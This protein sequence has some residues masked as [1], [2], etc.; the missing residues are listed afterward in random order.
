MVFQ[1]VPIMQLNTGLPLED[2]WAIASASVFPVQS[3][4]VQCTSLE[5]IRS[6]HI[7]AC[8]PLCVH[9][10][11]RELFELSWFHMYCNPKCTKTIMVLTSKTYTEWSWSTYRFEEQNCYAVDSIKLQVKAEF[12]ETCPLA[13]CWPVILSFQTGMDAILFNHMCL[14][15]CGLL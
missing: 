11:W 12:A 8:T 3:S 1:C 2:Q 5:I 6:G 9:L 13:A 14:G 7:P 10:V 4:M 15:V